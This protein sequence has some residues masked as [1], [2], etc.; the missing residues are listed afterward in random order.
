MS[1]LLESTLGLCELV[2]SSSLADLRVAFRLLDLRHLPGDR[3]EP[4]PQPVGSGPELVDAPQ[5]ADD[6]VES[7]CYVDVVPLEL[8]RERHEINSAIVAH[9]PSIADA[10]RGV[11]SWRRRP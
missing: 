8:A 7:R 1:N 3:R 6:D 2:P 10:G 5:E 4:G 9:R 11:D